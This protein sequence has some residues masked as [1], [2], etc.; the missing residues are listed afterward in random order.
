MWQTATLF[1]RIWVIVVMVDRSQVFRRRR[2][3]KLRSA[4]ADE[5]GETNS[6]RTSLSTSLNMFLTSADMPRKTDSIR[7]LA[8]LMQPSQLYLQ[9][10]NVQFGIRAEQSSI[11]LSCDENAFEFHER[12]QADTSSERLRE[13]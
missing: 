7:Q 8:D 4:S 1:K 11:N 13:L 6:K 3:L 2:Q 12:L 9:I 10:I 5:H